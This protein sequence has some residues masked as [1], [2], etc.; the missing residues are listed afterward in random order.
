MTIFSP[1][2]AAVLNTATRDLAADLHY[3]DRAK[4]LAWMERTGYD[5]EDFQR[6]AELMC[7]DCDATR[8]IYLDEKCEPRCMSCGYPYLLARIGDKDASA[9]YD[10][11]VRLA[12]T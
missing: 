3:R 8:S 2:L 9:E 1:A 6:A 7:S 11:L 10:R 4:H 5:F 12:I